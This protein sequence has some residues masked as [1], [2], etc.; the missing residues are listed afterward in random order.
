MQT[1]VR[2]FCS[3]SH[4]DEKLLEQLKR[5]LAPLK[6]Q[7]IIEVWHDRK[8]VVGEKWQSAID[9]NLELADVII[10]LVSASFFYS[11]YCYWKEM[12]RALE[13]HDAG[14]A[15]VI[16]VIVRS[17]IWRETPLSK[18]NALPKDG[19]AVTIW[20]DRDLAWTN[21][22]EGIR[23]VIDTPGLQHFYRWL[24]T[25]GRNALLSQ[26]VDIAPFLD[27]LSQD[28]RLGLTLIVRPS[29]EVATQLIAI[30]DQLKQLAPR[31]FYYDRER[32]HFT[33]VSLI[34]AADPPQV[35]RDSAKLYER[36]I[37]EVLGHFPA[38]DVVFLGICATRNSIIARGFP[39]D[40][41]L[42]RLRDALR[43]RLM[44]VGLGR[45]FDDR[46][47]IQ[48]AHITLA[49]VKVAENFS[50]LV[51]LIGQLRNT[52][53]GRMRVQ[54]AQ[55]VLNDFYMST[56]K[57]ELLAELPLG[58]VYRPTPIPTLPRSDITPQAPTLHNLK[59]K[60]W[61]RNVV[62]RDDE[63]KYIIRALSEADKPVIIASGFGGIGKSTL[64]MIVARGCVEQQGMF[65]FISWVDIRKYDESQ[66][67]SLNYILDEIAKTADINSDILSINRLDAKEYRVKEL[68]KSHRSLLIL[69]NYESLLDDHRE[70]QKVSA[71]LES[72]PIG[73]MEG[74]CI[75]ALITTREL[76]AGLKALPIDD[77]R[78]QELSL[79]DSVE[80]MK[81]RT[82]KHLRLTD[83]QYKRV[84]EML[85][86][87]PK[88]ME[89]AIDQ[90]K[91]TAFE[92]WEK[93]ITDIEIPL[94]EGEKFFRDLFKHSWKRFSDDFKKILLST[95][96]F[97][98]EASPEA[99]QKTSGLPARQFRNVLVNASDAYIEST[100]TGYT[101]HPLTHAYCRAVLDTSDFAEFREHAGFRFVEYFSEFSETAY[102]ASKA[103]KADLLERE[104]RNIVAAAR[105]AYKLQAWHHLIALQQHIAGFLRI[106]GSWQEQTEITR[107]ATTACRELGEEEKLA[108]C[109]VY[110]LGW[111]FLRFED[112]EKAEY[113]IKE[114][115]EVFQKLGHREGIAQATRHLGKSALLKGLDPWYKPTESSKQHFY[116]AERLYTE[117]F[118]IRKALEQG[119]LDQRNKIADMK[120]DFGRLYWLQ[121]QKYERDGREQQDQELIKASLEKYE[122][123]NKVSREAM[124]IF[125]EICSGRGMAKA[126]GN[127][128][129]ATKDIVRFLLSEGQLVNAISRIVE[130]HE[131]Y[132]KSLDVAKRIKR[133]DEITHAL[134]G[135][136]EVHELFADHPD[137]HSGFGKRKELFAK[138]LN[139]AKESHGIYMSLGGSKDINA[140][141]RLID[142]INGKLSS[143]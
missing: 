57:A 92:D 94:D 119:G 19:K 39:A 82:P 11:E 118:R 80:L 47:R 59:I 99:L 64:A 121:G 29:T 125:E 1:P 20:E 66:T 13:R 124:V 67:I 26:D 51:T 117:S 98:G 61:P 130:T 79:E 68:L 44:A 23:K 36:T 90:L 28:K 35:T 123:A 137:L 38:F 135:L 127:L 2:I 126:W 8:I 55:L 122:Q 103:G 56:N 91:S 31:H 12:K 70:E 138:A 110:D 10:F 113:Y 15:R 34:T 116:E 76:S 52:P 71:F 62:G 86:G 140:T 33:I 46:Y 4:E 141:Q 108:Q 41:T 85:C 53:L 77:M 60:Q 54:R 74:S 102:K 111:L 5:H 100:G 83:N 37:K 128:G 134:W 69:D 114:G 42:D 93:I 105:L 120:L 115:L 131:Y 6:N 75:R 109:L 88:Y 87:L 107:L 129:N 81:L 7:G 143:L 30:N 17:C 78:L 89:I 49:R 45:G 25:E 142:R 72:L 96:Y 84:W 24:C 58:D 22:V 106:R 50:P 43:E 27:D 139:Y 14:E 101:V 63:H 48:G 95:T 112:L 40:D 97:V 16:P 104:I 73:S 9:Q 3:Y 136:A 65:D 132:E 21:V 133:K 32:F 18:L